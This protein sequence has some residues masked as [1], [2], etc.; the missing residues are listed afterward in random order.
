MKKRILVT[1]TTYR[2]IDVEIPDEELF[3]DLIEDLNIVKEKDDIVNFDT[4]LEDID[5]DCYSC[6]IIDDIEEEE[7]SIE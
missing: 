3:N 7:I 1:H 2:Y 4:I 6:E 5:L